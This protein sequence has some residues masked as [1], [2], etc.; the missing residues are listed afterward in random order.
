MGCA[1]ICQRSVIDTPLA[2]PY[3]RGGKKS[4]RPAQQKVAWNLGRFE[5]AAADFSTGHPNPVL[6]R[7][8]ELFSPD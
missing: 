3:Q 8:P 2:P 1:G 4:G 5:S 6:D 7:R